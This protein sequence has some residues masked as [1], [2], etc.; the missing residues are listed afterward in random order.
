MAK[1]QLLVKGFVLDKLV[2]Q[3]SAVTY[4]SIDGQVRTMR[5]RSI[6]RSKWYEDAAKLSNKCPDPYPYT[7]QG[8]QEVFWRSIIA[9]RTDTKRPAPQY[10]E[11]I[12]NLYREI[13]KAR[14]EAPIMNTNS[15]HE[16]VF[17]TPEVQD[18][19]PKTLKERGHL[20]EYMAAIIPV[21]DGRRFGITE[22]G[23]MCLTPPESKI[24]DVVAIFYGSP[25]PFLLRK[26]EE[27]SMKVETRD[28]VYKLVGE[29]YVHG[30]M[31]SFDSLNGFIARPAVTFQIS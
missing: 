7:H 16:H 18:M 2:A 3:M 17:A 14:L 15:W 22:D 24:G 5:E 9:D 4:F 11:E 8:R 6:L 31:D 30:F 25:T 28:C 20:H 27:C 23:Y 13:C 12:H 10:L 1:L 26:D 21:G 19:W 29:C